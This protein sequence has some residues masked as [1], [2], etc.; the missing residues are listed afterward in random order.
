MM[1]STIDLLL[2]YVIP[3]ETYYVEKTLITV[4]AGL[5]KHVKC[6]VILCKTM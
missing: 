2:D 5:K 3:I 1:V 4:F 6:C